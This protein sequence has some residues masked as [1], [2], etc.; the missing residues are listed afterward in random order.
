MT[1]SYFNSTGPWPLSWV[2]D[3]EV[4]AW[5]DP[6]RFQLIPLVMTAIHKKIVVEENSE[7]RFAG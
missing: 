7:T 1:N 5:L 3:E 6:K 2:S 4:P